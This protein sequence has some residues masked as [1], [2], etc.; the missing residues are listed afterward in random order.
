[1][2]IKYDEHDYN[3]GDRASHVE[4]EQVPGFPKVPQSGVV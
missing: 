1:M 3:K 4:K 2:A